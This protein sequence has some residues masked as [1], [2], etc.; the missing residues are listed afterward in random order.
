MDLVEHYRRE[1]ALKYM[2]VRYDDVIDRQKESRLQM[3]VFCPRALPSPV[4]LFFTKTAATRVPRAMP[5]LPRSP[6]SACATRR[7]AYRDKLQSVIPIL[8]PV[9]AAWICR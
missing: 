4:A 8:A 5:R 9:M 2:A 7:R 6:T 3:L 1:M